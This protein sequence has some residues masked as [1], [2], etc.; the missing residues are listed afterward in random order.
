MRIYEQGIL[1]QDIVDVLC[2]NTRNSRERL[3]DLRSQYAGCVSAEKR[4]LAFCEK[5][6]AE[7][8]CQAMEEMLNASERL[9]RTAISEIPDGEY[10]YEDWCDGDGVDDG[11]IKIAATITV[12]G[13]SI[14]VDFSGSARQT[15]GGMNAPLAVTVSAT[16][17]AIKC[18]TDPQNP[19]N[20]G[21]YR[22]VTINAPLGSVVNP[23]PPAPVVAGNHE[24]GS[25]I[26]DVVISALSEALPK[27]VC[28]ADSGSSALLLL[29]T[30]IERHEGMPRELVMVEVHGAGHGANFLHDGLNARRTNIGNTANTPNEILEDAFPITVIS[31]GI[32]PDGVGLVG[33]E[34]ELASRESCEWSRSAR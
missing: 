15:R 22:P 17:Y 32:S 34:E 21:S 16:F 3:G 29:G 28:A 11:T 13:D 18:L 26:A 4:V 25:R 12:S 31:Y 5:Y 23:R 19:A 1:N 8:V 33:A 20:S 6:G 27:R 9:T 10:Y 7:V 14:H 24:T 30:Q 2:A